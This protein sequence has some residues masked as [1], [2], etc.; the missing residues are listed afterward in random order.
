MKGFSVHVSTHMSIPAVLN[1]E[2]LTR[3]ILAQALIK[4][5]AQYY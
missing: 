2:K 3:K 5:Y 4:N 1:P